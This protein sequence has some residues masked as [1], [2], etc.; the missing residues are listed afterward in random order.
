[1]YATR[2]PEAGAV[3]AGGVANEALSLALKKLIAQ[4]RPAARCAALATCGKAGMPSSHAQVGTREERGGVRTSRRL[5]RSPDP[6]LF[7]SSLSSLPPPPTPCSRPAPFAAPQK[8][9]YWRL[10]RGRCAWRGC[11]SATTP[12]PKSWR[13]GP[14]EPPLAPPWQ[15]ASRRREPARAA[16]GASEGRERERRQE[17]KR[18]HL[19]RPRV[20]HASPPPLPPPLPLPPTPSSNR[21]T[22][23][24][25]RA[26]GPRRRKAS[27]SFFTIASFSDATLNRAR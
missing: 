23:S 2:H 8:P 21:H 6:P 5:G 3:L 11:T 16:S 1:V 22:Q 19:T 17:K 18:R 24:M 20:F 27:L 12:S 14:W 7:S 15:P 10:A 26:S 4:P 13:V 25:M 9:S